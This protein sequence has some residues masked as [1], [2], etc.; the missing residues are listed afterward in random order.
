MTNDNIS[1]MLT[2]IRNGSMAKHNFVRI[3]YSKV[4]LAILKV[5]VTEGYIKDFEIE[6]I[7]FQ[8]TLRKQKANEKAKEEKLESQ[9]K[10][11]L[12]ENVEIVQDQNAVETIEEK[13][14]SQKIIKVYLKYKGW[15]IKKSFFSILKRISK[16]GK[17][18]FSNYKNFNNSINVL[19]Y[20]Q[21]IAIISTSSGVM[22]HLKATQLKKGGEI[23]CYIG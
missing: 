16:P 23:L 22:S 6:I 2:R 20:Q 3:L 10:L 12:I 11:N 21:G 13:K 17:R 9:K 19:R 1:D 5:L 7:P 4:N 8:K 18:V 15:W 14:Y